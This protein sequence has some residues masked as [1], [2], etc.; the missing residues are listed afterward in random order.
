MNTSE[1]IAATADLQQR[2]GL[3]EGLLAFLWSDAEPK[4]YR[5]PAAGTQACIIGALPRA[6]RG[7]TVYCDKEHF[8]CG[9]CGY[10][11]GFAPPRPTI[12]AFVS[13]GIPGQMEGEHY[14]KS[15]ELVRRM[16]EANPPPVPPARF[17][18]FK[19]VA[20]LA[21][22]ER[23]EVIF[24]FGNGDE[25]SGLVS[26]ANYDRADDAVA[27]VFA[28]GCG[29][30]ITR[31]LNEAKRDLPRAVLGLFDPSARPCVGMEELSFSA[32]LALWE[33]MLI[34][35]PESFLTTETWAR[36]RGRLTGA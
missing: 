30:L 33:Q 20:G 11:L 4:G 32:P 16:R 12:D 28:S 31:P 2:L 17:A 6:R 36:V 25:L 23:P 5:L 7:Q 14:K 21:P 27:C 34:N 22:D 8:G 15:P 1:L 18:V 24:Y 19:P 10:Y 13:T 35:A 26:L 29:T 3:R 9:G